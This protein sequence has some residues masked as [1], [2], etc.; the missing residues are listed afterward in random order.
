MSLEDFYQSNICKS[1]SMCQICRQ[2]GK[3]RENLAKEY[4]FELHNGCFECPFSKLCKQ[5]QVKDKP[6]SSLEEVMEVCKGCI[7]YKTINGVT[8]CNSCGCKSRVSDISKLQKC[9][10]NLWL[11]TNK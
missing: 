2:N 7:H 10:Y 8:G 11:W 4:D 5:D 1:K 6:V 3:F 9:P